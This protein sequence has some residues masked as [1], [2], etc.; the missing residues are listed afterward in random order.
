MEAVENLKRIADKYQHGLVLK[1]K[2]LAAL[3]QIQKR[4]GD[5]LIN[6]PVGYGKTSFTTFYRLF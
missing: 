2:Q 1:E 5:M 3:T 4:K 6:L